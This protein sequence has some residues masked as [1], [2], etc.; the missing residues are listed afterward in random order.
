MPMDEK[1]GATAE[2][3]LDLYVEVIVNQRDYSWIPEVF[4]P[5]VVL[6]EPVGEFYGHRGIETY[7]VSLTNGFPDFHGRVENLVIQN[8]MVVYEWLASGTHT[9][10]YNGLPPTGH[11]VEMPGMTMMRFADGKFQDY[12]IYYDTAQ[13]LEQLGIPL[14]SNG[15]D[16]TKL[17]LKTI[18]PFDWRNGVF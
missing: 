13:L 12:R 17:A 3:L 1:A 8:E 9:G 10:E 5:S 16:L 6:R 2:W 14:P 15:T 11:P 7:L 18:V 4:S